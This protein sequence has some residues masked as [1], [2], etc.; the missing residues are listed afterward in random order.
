MGNRYKQ[1]TKNFK[2]KDQKIEMSSNETD[3]VKQPTQP[4]NAK[5]PGIDS[6]SQYGVEK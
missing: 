3:W 5:A 4:K 6:S 1:R 2:D